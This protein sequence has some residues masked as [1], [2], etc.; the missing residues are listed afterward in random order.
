[1]STPS[2]NDLYTPLTLEQVMASILEV[3]GILDLPITAWQAEGV[4]RE[5]LTVIAQEMANFSEVVTPMAAG[6]L[7]DFSRGVW[8]TLLADQLY[9][10]QRIEATSGTTIENLTNTSGTAYTIAPGD[11]RF[12]NTVSGANYTN[13]T[14]GTLGAKVGPVNGTLSITVQADIPGIESNAAIGEIGGISTP[15]QG[16]TATNAAPLVGTDQESD[17]S[18][19]ERCQESLA[20]VTLS[21]PRDAYN[22]YAKT[23]FKPD[24]SNVGVTRTSVSDANATITVYLATASGVVPPSDVA[25]VNTNIQANC[26]PTGFTATVV[27][28]DGVQIDVT[29]TVYLSKGSTLDNTQAGLR[30]RTQLLAYFATIPIGGSNIG[31]GGQVFKNKITGQILD[32]SSEFVQVTVSAPV[33]DVPLDANQV[34]VLGNVTIN[35]V[36]T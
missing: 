1:M 14:G 11:L 13:T 9:D 20:R 33:A 34:A 5:I 4:A 24:G 15:R 31:G 30:V 17:D 28:A 36:A 32:A 35:A 8:L 18:L 10:V 26:V 25:L 19:R 22:Y 3:A 21:G 29:A 12:Y 27:A 2:L 23:T 7:L 16:V 6:G